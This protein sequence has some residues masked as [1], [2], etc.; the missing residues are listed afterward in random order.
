MPEGGQDFHNRG[1]ADIL[2]L[3]IFLGCKLSS[4]SLSDACS[5]VSQLCHVLSEGYRYQRQHLEFV[6]QFVKQKSSKII[7][8]QREVRE[9]KEKLQSHQTNNKITFQEQI[10]K[11]K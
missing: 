4:Q 8:M 5:R 1:A 3:L 2:M 7:M 6:V 10:I 11:E 9:M